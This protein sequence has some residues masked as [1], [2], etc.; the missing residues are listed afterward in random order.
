[1][2]MT[3]KTI[4]SL[5]VVAAVAAL[6]MLLRVALAQDTLLV[7]ADSV[8]LKLENDRVRVLQSNLQPGGKEKMHSH[9]SYVIYVIKGGRVRI[10]NADGKTSET[11]VKAGD[12]IFRDP[13]THWAENIGTTEI[14]EILVELKG[15]K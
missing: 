11:D 1:M 8:H 14:A 10:H 6:S 15:Q 2:E 7:N 5:V 9:P 13:V 12:V 3:M 4:T